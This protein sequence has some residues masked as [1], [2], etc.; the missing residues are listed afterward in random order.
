MFSIFLFLNQL[1]KQLLL[2]KTLKHNKDIKQTSTMGKKS[3]LWTRRDFIKTG[4]ITVSGFALGCSIRP[5]LDILIR[6]GMIADGTGKAM[7][8][9]DVGIRNGKIAAVGNLNNAGADFVI[10]ATNKVV[11][12]GFID[13]H[14]H[15]DSELLVTPNAEGKIRQGVTTEVSGNCGSSLF[16]MT[17][18][19]AQRNHES[20][21]KKYGLDLYWENLDGFYSILEKQG[22]ALNYVTF[23][24]HGDLR[25]T[26]MGSYDRD[27]STDELKKMQKILAQT[28]EMGSMGLSTGLEYAPG[29]YAKTSEL[30][31]LS[32][33]VS[34]YQGVYA[35]HLRNE[36]DRL[37]EAVEEAL[38]ICR[39]AQVSL[40]ISH[41]K[42]CNRNNWNKIDR[43][44]DTIEHAIGEGLPIRA[45]RY[46]YNA[47][48]T[49]LSAFLPVSARQGSTAEIID[50][51]KKRDNEE[52][53]RTYVID[54]G[55]RIGGWDRVLIS[56]CRGEGG[57][58]FE[59]KTLRDIALA[60]HTSPYEAVRQLL[61]DFNGQVSTI[62]FAMD[63]ENLKKVLKS[64]FVTV[65][66]DGSVRARYGPLFT[67]KPHP[68]SYGTFP[69]ILAK[70]VREEKVLTI[71]EAVRKMSAMNAEKLNLKNRGFIRENYAAD[72]VLF[73]PETVQD[74]ST[75][76]DPHQYPTGISHVI[77]NG[78]PVIKDRNHTGAL[79]GNVLRRT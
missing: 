43:V 34:R 41:L 70:Y 55:E 71:P 16:P 12:P 75:Y 48:S 22:I 23:T 78:V 28:L 60:L 14:A 39:K 76:L 58:F 1:K 32:N 36:D 31:E 30:I 27:P 29:S 3:D 47:W 59:G 51:L 21:E 79:P 69:R 44:L 8:K 77:V 53:I 40:Q 56:S 49:G 35:T 7:F 63:D 26:V 61:I 65:G 66:S 5:G 68:R 11:S 10:D 24:G 2:H 13:I 57:E 9:S 42:A 38:D 50:M 15:S 18:E 19:A 6:N 74:N 52:F 20:L 64:E 73:D 25:D 4:I 46:P 33:V 45:D 67:G 54:R 17:K 62:G 37:E 72:L